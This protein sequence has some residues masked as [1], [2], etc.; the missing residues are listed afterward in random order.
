MSGPIP[1]FPTDFNSAMA[2]RYV[3]QYRRQG[4]V[5]KTGGEGLQEDVLRNKAV[6]T[7]K[8]KK[9]GA[10]VAI[11]H[12]GGP[13]IDEALEAAGIVP[14]KIDGVRVTDAATLEITH[15]C[16]NDINRKFVNIF[17]EEA[18]KMGG[19]ISAIGLGGNDGKLITAESIMAGS[20]T[21]KVI[22]VDG[23]KLA[24]MTIGDDVP[25]I[26]PIC[27][28][29]DGVARNVNAD[30]VAAAVAMSLNAQRLILCSNI[31]GVLDKNKN[32]IPELFVEDVEDLIANGTITGGMI[33]KVRSA[34]EVAKRG[35]GG[36]V[37][38]DWAD[39][40]AIEREIFTDLGAG[41]LIKRRVERAP[42]SD[43]ML[44]HK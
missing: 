17:N 3:E 39:P 14:Q 22:D 23:Y 31:P 11:I 6:Q 36:V 43:F 9:L 13:Q 7:I 5:I 24:Q 1:D 20:F 16:L 34:A 35:V 18:A 27:I 26:H 15:R 44:T 37:I 33:P 19:D 38:L 40:T 28:G 41:T 4:I 8:L 21:G 30:E 25:I 10:R 12:G 32:K 42:A 29:K 2:V